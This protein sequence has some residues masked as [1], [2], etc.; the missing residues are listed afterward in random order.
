[1]REILVLQERFSDFVNFTGDVRAVC[2]TSPRTCTEPDPRFF[3]DAWQPADITTWPICRAEDPS[4]NMSEPHLVCELTG[5]PCCFG[6]QA[7]CN[8]TTREQCDFLDGRFHQEAFLCSQVHH[9]IASFPALLCGHVVLY[10][11]SI[12]LRWTVCRT[13][14]VSYP[15]PD[16]T[17]LTRSTDSI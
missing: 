4:A 17:I 7:N 6:V 2:G 14:V 5:R 11:N 16:L 3:P 15:L 12:L 13:S 10:P 9:N 8:I 1:M